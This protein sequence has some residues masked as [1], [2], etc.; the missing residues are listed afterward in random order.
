MNKGEKLFV[1]DL[2]SVS[3]FSNT[4]LKALA[5]EEQKYKK[6]PFLYLIASYVRNKS[7]YWAHENLKFNDK[8]L[9]GSWMV[10]SFEK[11]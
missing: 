10:Y 1:V 3:I 6:T 2:E 5:Q 4:D 8:I 11:I 9:T 7:L